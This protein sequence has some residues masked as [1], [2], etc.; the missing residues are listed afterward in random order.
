MNRPSFLS[1]CFLGII[2]LILGLTACQGV[3]TKAEYPSRREGDKDAV[4]GQ[5]ESISGKGGLN[6]FGG[7]KDTDKGTGITVNAYLWRAAL[8]TVSF[9]PIDK[10]DPFGGTIIT[11]WYSTPQQPNE[12]AKV[13]VF[14]IGRELRTDALKV[15]LFRQIG[16]NGQWVDVAVDP[17]TSKQLEETILNR[18]RQ[19]K[20]AEGNA[21]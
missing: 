5:R 1:A 15:S 9:M 18:A 4:Y 17:A 21:E 10:A 16:Q 6:L 12:R 7:R 14:I 3:E 2:C 13:N 11:E 20:V 8:D 19:L